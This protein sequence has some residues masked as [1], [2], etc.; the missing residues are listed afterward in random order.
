MEKVTAPTTNTTIFRDQQVKIWNLEVRL[1]MTSNPHHRK[2]LK[3]KIESLKVL[4][5]KVNQ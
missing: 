3:S 4:L 5:A 1:R 2:A